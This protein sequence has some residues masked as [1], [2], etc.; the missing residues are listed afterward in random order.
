ME[1]CRQPS[2]ASVAAAKCQQHSETR[3]LH[4]DHHSHPVHQPLACPLQGIPMTLLWYFVRCR[5]RF[6]QPYNDRNASVVRDRWRQVS[7][8]EL[9]GL[10]TT[11]ETQKSHRLNCR[12][13]VQQQTWCHYQQP[14]SH[15]I[16]TL[17]RQCRTARGRQTCVGHATLAL[18]QQKC[19]RRK[20]M[21]VPSPHFLA[22]R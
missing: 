22:I 7:E 17:S 13:V 3:M 5:P 16:Q 20:E 11:C 21:L 8:L 6:A 9:S 19:G 4:Q 15:T 10:P 2:Q 1:I 14:S 12:R 18:P